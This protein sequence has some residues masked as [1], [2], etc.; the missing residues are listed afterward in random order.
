MAKMAMFNASG[1]T[2]FSICLNNSHI[3]SNENC[4]KKQN[5][6]KNEKIAVFRINFK[7]LRNKQKVKK[8][9]NSGPHLPE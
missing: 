5:N 9:H 3:E 8:R 6:K 1:S 7:K 4:K 2:Q